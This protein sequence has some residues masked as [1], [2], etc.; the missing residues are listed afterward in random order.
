MEAG[1]TFILPVQLRGAY[2]QFVCKLSYA[3]AQV[4]RFHLT[5]KTQQ[6]E[7]QKILLPKKRFA[8]KLLSCN[9]EF[10]HEHAGENLQIIFKEL[11]NWIKKPASQIEYLRNKK[12]W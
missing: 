4:M 2:I 9:F 8:W 1:E 6:M 11:D 10:K 5:Y 12:S 7:L 3:S